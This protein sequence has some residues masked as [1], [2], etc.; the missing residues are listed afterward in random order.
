MALCKRRGF[1][2]Q[3]SEIYGGINGFWDY[4]PLGAQL[5]R[6]LR[7]A[8]W[9]D[10]VMRPCGGQRGPDGQPVRIVP[11]D[12]TIIQHPR[13]LG[14]ERARGELQRSHDR[15]PR[16][17][18]A[19]PLRSRERLRAHLGASSLRAAPAEGTRLSP[20]DEGKPFFAFVGDMP[21]ESK[22]KKKAEKIYGE[23]SIV[24][25]PSVPKSLRV[26]VLAPDAEKAG[27]LTEPRAF[28]LMFKTYIGA[29]ATEDNIAYL[30]PETAQGIFV[31]FKN[32]VDTTRVEDALRHR[33]DRQG[34]RNEVTPRNFTFRSREFEQMEIEFFC[35]PERSAGVVRVLARLPH[36]VVEDRSA[37]QATTSS[38]ASTRRTSSR[39]TPRTARARR[40][41][42]P[43]P[44]HCARLRRARRR[45]PP[46]R[47]RPQP[48]HQ[49]VQQGAS[50][51]TS[52]RTAAS[53]C[54]T[55]R[56][57]GENASSRT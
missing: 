30:R 5:K 40:H 17:Q 39:T 56:R 49:A 48:Q 35:H 18:S 52:T 12:S 22:Q 29:T 32:V 11:L 14:S 24:P 36:G 37:S 55:A 33:A 21:S 46:R 26:R 45:R 3:A 31:N 34:F 42:V 41:R 20:T 10:T 38:C 4:G 9:E 25:L 15:L 27:S 16:N 13:G 1:I 28:N 44:L 2:Y 43:L 53:C 50:S 57:K 7:D 51:S 23:L 6:N 54:P 19:L 8:W 47:L